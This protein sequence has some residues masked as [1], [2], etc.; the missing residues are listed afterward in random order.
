MHA[1][2]QLID[3]INTNFDRSTPTLVAYIDF[4]KAFDSVNHAKLIKKLKRF[5]LDSK[6]MDWIVNYFSNR[7]QKTIA[8]NCTSKVM[9]ITQ[10]VPQG[11]IL[12]PLFY[13][14]YANDL[15]DFLTNTCSTYYA[16]D[17]V[18]YTKE[19]NFCKASRLLQRDL[20]N[21]E[22]WCKLNDIFVN[23]KKTKYMIFGSKQALQNIN[24]PCL[25]INGTPLSRTKT[26]NYLGI[27]LDEQLNY[28][29]HLS[30]VI[31]KVSH[32]VYQLKR[33]RRFIN[34]K[35][36]LAVYKNMI[37]PIHEYGDIL[38]VSAS[39]ENRKRLQT[40]QNKA[41]KCALNLDPTAGTLETHRLAKLDKL[42]LRR[43]EHLLIHMFKLAQNVNM[44]KKRDSKKIFTRSSL[45]KIM[46][47]KRPNTEKYR[48]SVTYRGK[49]LWNNLPTRLHDISTLQFFKLELHKWL[50]V[51]KNKIPLRT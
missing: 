17:T 24:E 27:N 46:S 34:K 48:K 18:L 51:D 9:T 8:N 50:T 30:G 7:A 25:K 10:G 44:L 2:L 21:L 47:N 42:N 32:K 20:K 45:K 3:Q 49:Q 31:R 38:F 4:Q 13:I 33:M 11:S 14:L 12:G 19:K 40:L 26:Y 15:V 6:L 36:A 29:T 28:E 1:L 41:L 35:A 5:N 16:D 37:L 39:Y 22:R 43:S 23:I